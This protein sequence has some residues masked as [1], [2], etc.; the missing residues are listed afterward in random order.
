MYTY[1]FNLKKINIKYRKHV[2]LEYDTKDVRFK[3][4]IWD[5]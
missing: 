3:K 2:N 1:F 5:K 4:K